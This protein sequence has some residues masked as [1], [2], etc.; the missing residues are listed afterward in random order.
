MRSLHCPGSLRPVVSAAILAWGIDPAAATEADLAIVPL[1]DAQRR[2]L[3]NGWGGTWSRGNLGELSL[4]ISPLRPE[5]PALCLDLG[6][7]RP[8]ECR[9]AE[10]FASAQG[11]SGAYYQTRDLG[12]YERVEFDV[13]NDTGAPLQCA[14]QCIDDNDHNPRHAVYRYRLEPDRVWTHIVVPLHSPAADSFDL[15][16][17]L[18]IDFAFQPEA[19]LAG[20]RVYLDRLLLVEP[21]APADV[22]VSPLP[23]LVERLARRQWDGLWAAR[24]RNHGMIPNVSYQTTDAGLNTTAAVLWMLP[25][26]ERRAW[27]SP[28]EGR[29]YIEQLVH[30][31]DRLLD[32]AHHV[33][34]R[35]LDWV[36]LEPSLLPEES[37]VDAAF[38]A[39]ALRQYAPAPVHPAETRGR[40]RTHC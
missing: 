26:A 7:T 19:S 13:F 28:L 24:S 27:V 35:N 17:T 23:V 15:S 10:C 4:Q 20:G 39:L 22:N 38:L 3:I 32:R 16:R 2:E 6:P 5:R 40:H 31:V 11:R 34:P 30:T 33:P 37:A 36:T 21:G 1:F 9:Y 8:C 29:R 25:A 18:A 14:L 12:R